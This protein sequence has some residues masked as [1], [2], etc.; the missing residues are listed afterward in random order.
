MVALIWVD[1]GALVK[2]ARRNTMS[3]KILQENDNLLNLVI[4][5]FKKF[6]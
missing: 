1:T 2:Q 3:N 4:Y 5:A 6:W